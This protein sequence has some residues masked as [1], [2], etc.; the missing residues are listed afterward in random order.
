M[1]EGTLLSP[2]LI[3][4][5]RATDRVGQIDPGEDQRSTQYACHAGTE[6][7][8]PRDPLRDPAAF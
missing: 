3:P 6:R 5:E 4:L 1:G 8:R 7:P 2:A